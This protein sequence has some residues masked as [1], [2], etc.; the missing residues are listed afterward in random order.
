[1]FERSE[2]QGVGIEMTIESYKVWAEN[3]VKTVGINEARKLADA[4]VKTIE[5]EE[6]K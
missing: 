2:G 3:I 4:L 6:S 1:M 5:R